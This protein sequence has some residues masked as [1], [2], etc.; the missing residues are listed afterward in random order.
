HVLPGKARLG[1]AQGGAVEHWLVDVQA[2]A[3]VAG[4]DKMAHM[5]AGTA[6]QVEV[7]L[8]AVA[9]QLLQALHAV[10]LRGVVDVR[11][12]QIVIARQVGIE[13][14]AGHDDRQD[15]EGRASYP[16]RSGGNRRGWRNIA[17]PAS[18]DQGRPGESR[19]TGVAR[20]RTARMNSPASR[21]GNRPLPPRSMVKAL[22]DRYRSANGQ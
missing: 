22:S 16:R 17:A 1:A 3:G 14:V 10:A 6:G 20:S 4:I 15:F 8:A 9:E 19:P 18:K 11:A 12:H 21:P 13:G 2:A 7:T 5:R